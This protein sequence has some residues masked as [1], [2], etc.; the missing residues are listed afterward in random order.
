[1]FVDRA[2]ITIRAGKGGDGKVSFRRE[3][4]EPKGGPNGGDGGKGGDVVIVAEP[5]MTTLYDLRFESLY[6]AP[7]GEN[8]GQK[9]CFGG[10][11]EDLIIRLPPGTM[12]FDNDTGALVHDLKPGDRIVIAKGGKGGFGNEHYKSSTNQSPRNASAGEPGD[13][14][15]ARLELKLIAEIGLV[16]MP[17]AGKSTLLKA[18]TRANPKIADYPFT[19]LSPQLGIAELTGGRR[20][21]IADIPGLIEGA[22]QGAGLGHDFLRH[23]ER[24]KVLVHLLDCSPPD[25]STPAANYETIRAELQAYSV[26]LAERPELIVLNKIDTLESDKA[27]SDALLGLCKSLGVRPGKE[28]QA[29]SGATRSNIDALLERLWLMLHPKNEKPDGWKAEA[30]DPAAKPKPASAGPSER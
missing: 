20:M 23:L 30:L 27:R 13:G 2:I 4:F 22:S 3:K 29:I 11:G 12:I 5:G 19:T 7:D 26:E 1:M 18:L 17:N 14:F 10:A 25:G 16:G 9:Q 8:G 15:E 21:V 6:K 28:A 24:T